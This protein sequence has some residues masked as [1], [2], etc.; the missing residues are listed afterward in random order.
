M[1]D[2]YFQFRDEVEDII[3]NCE[4]QTKE[5]EILRVSPSS[6]QRADWIKSEI[7]AKLEQNRKQIS[8]LEKMNA[9]IAE[10]PS[11]FNISIV[12]VDERRAFVAKS[13]NRIYEIEARLNSPMPDTPE[14]R[15]I[16]QKNKLVRA[17]VE[18]NQ[19]FIDDE[20]NRQQELLARQDGNLELIDNDVKTIR[21]IANEINDELSTSN[22][23][24]NS[25]SG[26]MDGTN[27]KIERATGK[28]Q[29][30]LN[31][32]NAWLTTACVV[33]TIILIVLIYWALF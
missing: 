4:Q 17:K 16:A 21:G 13:R 14:T 11:R 27:D 2:P 12:E 19:N 24:I 26:H 32:D 10:N 5:W 31:A 15:A 25:L 20:M 1:N 7:L 22:Q 6:M 23:R 33:L 9:R 18:D 8:D 28:M 29:Q 30:L 3:Q